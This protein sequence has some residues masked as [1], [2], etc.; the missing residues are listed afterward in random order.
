MGQ[1]WG[2]GDCQED[3][4]GDGKRPLPGWIPVRMEACPRLLTGTQ[5]SWAA[6]PTEPA[7]NHLVL[8]P[9]SGLVNRPLL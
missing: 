9:S 7:R 3:E 6:E 2:Q 1:G 4:E 5:A 8:C